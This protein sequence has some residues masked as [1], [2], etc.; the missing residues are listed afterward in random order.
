MGEELHVS[1]LLVQVKPT[2]LGAVRLEIGALAGAEIFAESEAGKL[3]VVIESET[4]GVIADCLSTISAMPGVLSASLIY[5][6]IS[7][8]HGTVGQQTS[9]GSRP[10]S[11]ELS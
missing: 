2:F 3:I 4:E 10:S 7:D 6:E 9:M 1:S 5:H 8:D 11:G